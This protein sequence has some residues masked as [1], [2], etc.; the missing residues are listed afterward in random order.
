[1]WHQAVK[2]QR[3]QKKNDFK[4]VFILS[5]KQTNKKDV[6]N[7]QNLIN[8]PFTVGSPCQECNSGGGHERAQSSK[9]PVQI[10]HHLPFSDTPDAD[11]DDGPAKLS[12]PN[13]DKKMFSCNTVCAFSIPL[14]TPLLTTLLI[15]LGTFQ[16]FHVT[17]FQKTDCRYA[18]AFWG[19]LSEAFGD[20]NV[21]HV[22]Y[23]SH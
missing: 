9:V 13:Y 2:K 6:A 3:T 10:S 1:M 5:E 19:V 16:N 7:V 15:Y 12:F 4:V 11:P 21:N 20:S 18:S 14:A 23:P 22:P 8:G 17:L